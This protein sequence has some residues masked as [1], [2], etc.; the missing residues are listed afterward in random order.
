MRVA[1]VEAA[2]RLG[3]DPNAAADGVAAAGVVDPALLALIN[4]DSKAFGRLSSELKVELYRRM[5]AVIGEGCTIG[6]GTVLS[7]RRLVLGDGAYFGPNC[8]VEVEELHAGALLHLGPRCR[9]RVTRARIGDNAFFAE[10]VE[11]GGGGALDPEAELIVGSH[12]FIG[13]RAHINACRPVRIGDEV[14]ISRGVS[15]MT[16]SFG[17]SFLEGYPS[18]FAGVTVGD[19]AQ[20]G[21]GA[22][23][24]P[25][26]EVGT[27]AILL[28]GSSLVSSVPPGRL[29]GGVPAVDL[30]AAATPLTPAEQETR[31]CGL[32]EELA[33]Q[34]QLRG[35]E[36]DVA[37]EDDETRVCV[38]HQGHRHLL[39]FG[40]S[41]FTGLDTAN[42][43]ELH[44]S[45]RFEAEVWEALPPE[46]TGIDLGVPAIRGAA[47]PLA[48]AFREFLRKRGVRLRPRAWTYTGG[49]L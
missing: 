8:L 38:M 20:L 14:V 28:S 23:L 29:F 27:G 48:D 45:L 30:K 12:G 25:G 21:I 9:L 4:A 2:A 32:V 39:R 36:V 18:R 22:V 26:V 5:G 16:H 42:A 6:P 33:R 31:A 15:L 10:D 7:A 41:P 1:D 43:E 46:V 17:A 49:W 40:S 11:V 13:E 3:S 19:G 35:K 34:L 37:R 24:F 44:V 47:G